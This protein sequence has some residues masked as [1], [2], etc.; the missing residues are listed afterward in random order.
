MN[1]ADPLRF[2]FSDSQ[3]ESLIQA[4]G[5]TDITAQAYVREAETCIAAYLRAVGGGFREGLPADVRRDLDAVLRH[6]AELRSALYRLP[7]DLAALLDL[8]L[9]GEGAW[10][11]L[12]SD[13]ERLSFPLEALAAAVQELREDACRNPDVSSEAMAERLV[14]ALAAAYRNHLNLQP[15]AEPGNPFPEVLRA[16]LA[17]AG[18]RDPELAELALGLRLPALAR[19][20]SAPADSA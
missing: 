1:D 5:R 11:R 4:I 16:T 3:T 7:D 15:R 14:R 12:N 9:L 6:S 13:L 19:M 20:L 17:A 10:R 8:H 18:S 2:A